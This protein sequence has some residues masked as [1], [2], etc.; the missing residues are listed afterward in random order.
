MKRSNSCTKITN[1]VRNINTVYTFIVLYIIQLYE[2]FYLH[3]S[4]QVKENHHLC[5]NCFS[6]FRCN[7]YIPCIQR[8]YCIHYEKDTFKDTVF[9][10][11]SSEC[12][13][14]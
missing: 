13:D 5:I 7:G 2:L 3:Q 9:Y 11:C 14:L 8:C 12:S 4:L 6:Q 1:C 10:L